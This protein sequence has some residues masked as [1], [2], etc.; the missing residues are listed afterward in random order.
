[1]NSFHH[2]VS[3]ILLPNISMQDNSDEPLQFP[4]SDSIPEL[5]SDDSHDELMLRPLDY[6]ALMEGMIN[7]KPSLLDSTDLPKRINSYLH[8]PT[9]YAT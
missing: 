3:T 2:V 9:Q 5:P 7:C 6:N 8:E 1:M 4:G